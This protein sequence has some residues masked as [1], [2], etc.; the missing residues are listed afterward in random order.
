MRPWNYEKGTLIIQLEIPA[1]WDSDPRLPF[2]YLSNSLQLP[3]TDIFN[4]EIVATFISSQICFIFDN[5]PIFFQTQWNRRV[6]ACNLY[7]ITAFNVYE[8]NRQ[9]GAYLNWSIL[10]CIVCSVFWVRICVDDFFGEFVN[11]FVSLCLIE[12]KSFELILRCKWLEDAP[13]LE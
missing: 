5:G 7:V 9:N 6:F 3:I 10:L 8:E 13:I 4:F 12:N 11:F 2:E 1:V